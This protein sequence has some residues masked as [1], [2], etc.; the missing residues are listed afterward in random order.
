MKISDLLDFMVRNSASDLHISSGDMPILRINGDIKRINV[1]RLSSE[2]ATKIIYDTMSE[3]LRRKFEENLELDFAYELDGIGR[4]RV[5]VFMQ[6]R[7]ISAVFRSIATEIKSLAD[8]NAPE[9]LKKISLTENGLVLVTGP[10][11]SGK[12][13]T[14]AAMI[15]YINTNRP[16]HIL[17]IEDPIEFV[18]PHKKS[19]ISQREL[20]THTFSFNNALKAA[21]RENPDVILVGELRDIET[22]RLAMTAAETGH[23]VMGTLHTVSAAKTIDRIIDIFPAEEK[24]VTRTILSESI[25]AVIS[26]KLIKNKAM[27]GMVSAQ[28]ILIGTSAVKNLIRE[29][30][31]SQIIGAM[32]VGQ[33]YGMQTMDQAI[34]NLME[35][36]TISQQ[37]LSES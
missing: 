9:V 30:K 5:N 18:H 21:L 14:L 16:S 2:A 34:E 6:K 20:E 22:I 23:L 24:A 31:V 25:K 15:D 12:S 7:G 27:S 37:S 1:E 35:S 28:E 11:G 3:K 10:T 33:Q 26:Q 36:G 29:S 17:T 8:L 32:Q 4:F 19:L 13:T